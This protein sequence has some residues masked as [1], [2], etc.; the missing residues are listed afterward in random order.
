MK[1]NQDRTRPYY[2]VLKASN[3]K[4]SVSSR[5]Y[6]SKYAAAHGIRSLQDNGQGH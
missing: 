3:G 4:V 6:K 1:C 2:F 5:W